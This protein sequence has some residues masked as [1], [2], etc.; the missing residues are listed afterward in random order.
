MLFG[1]KFVIF[2]GTDWP[3]VVQR[4]RISLDGRRVDFD[5]GFRE[6]LRRLVASHVVGFRQGA[7]TVGEKLRIGSDTVCASAKR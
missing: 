5:K 7:V 4:V 3:N 6:D 1:S 2:D